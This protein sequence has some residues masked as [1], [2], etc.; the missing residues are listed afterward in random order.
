MAPSTGRNVPA[1]TCNVTRRS[2]KA[3]PRR[4]Q[5]ASVKWSPAVGA[6]TLPSRSAYAVWYASSSE[7]S[8][9]RPRYGGTGTAPQ[10]SNKAPSVP[11][12]STSTTTSR[13][14]SSPCSSHGGPSSTNRSVA[15][16]PAT[17]SASFSLTEVD[18][19][20]ADQRWPV[21]DAATLA[22]GSLSSD[23]FNSKHSTS[24]PPTATASR[25]RTTL[26]SFATTSASLGRKRSRS[27][28]VSSPY[29][30]S[31]RATRSFELPRG[32]A[33]CAAMRSGGSSYA[34]RAR[35]AVAAIARGQACARGVRAAARRRSHMGCGRCTLSDAVV[36]S[37]S[38]SL[39]R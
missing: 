10:V 3:S 37:Q 32:D 26:L 25:A 36:R 11:A 33:G 2:S 18:R 5:C 35:R 24:S 12:A 19:S 23:G 7:S 31:S 15:A 17:G 1:P 39:A 22:A 27:A 4:A 16:A 34:K 14:S 28:N 29:V 13:P 21:A 8:A 6:A 30:V 9:S 20:I 38:C